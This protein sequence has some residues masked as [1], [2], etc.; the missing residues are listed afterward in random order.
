MALISLSS[1]SIGILALYLFKLFLF[2]KKHQGATLP[3][4]P[5]P[6]PLIGNLTDLPP[7]GKEEWVHWSKHKDL[8]GK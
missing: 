5:K 2:P 3:P 7:A 6:K 8:Y 4:G 1:L